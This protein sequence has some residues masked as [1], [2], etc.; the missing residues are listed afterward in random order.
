MELKDKVAI[1]T[2]STRGIGRGLAKRF[3]EEGASVVIV[4]RNEDKGK[5]IETEIKNSG[6]EATY[7][8]T[9]LTKEESITNMIECTVDKYDTI[10]ILVNNAAIGGGEGPFFELSTEDWQKRIETNLTGSFLCSRE[11]AKYMIKKRSG[12]IINVGSVYG[13]GVSA[14]MG[15]YASTKG[16]L[17]QLTK[18][19]AVD[20]APYNITVNGISPGAISTEVT[21][22]LD[23]ETDHPLLNHVLLKRQGTITEVADVIV[24]LASDRSSY[25]T[26]ENVVVDGGLLAHFPNVDYIDV[27]D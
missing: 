15:A 4:G 25:M 24:F 9:D 21:A 23:G 18:A 12:R 7:V 6:G 3:T 26:G 22:S 1:I 10:D 19:M 13:L 20:L 5:K 14:G 27:Y 16:G 17:I 8:Q 11:A 2:G